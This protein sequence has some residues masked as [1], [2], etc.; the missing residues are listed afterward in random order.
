MKEDKIT[1]LLQM[2]DLD[3]ALVPIRHQGNCSE[4][5]PRYVASHGISNECFLL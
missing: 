1:V 3:L 4:Y 5:L 2:S